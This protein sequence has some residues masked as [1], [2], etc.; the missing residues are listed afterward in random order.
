MLTSD[1]VPPV[2]RA[3]RNLHPMLSTRETH[4]IS[5]VLTEE[6]GQWNPGFVPLVTSVNAS[7]AAE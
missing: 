4:C 1:R 7:A 5:A 3:E 6:S 2:D